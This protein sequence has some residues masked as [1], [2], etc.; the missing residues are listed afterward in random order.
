MSLTQVRPT[1][2]IILSFNAMLF[3]L[4]TALFGKGVLKVYNECLDYVVKCVRVMY[5]VKK[6]QAERAVTQWVLFNVELCAGW[7]NIAD[8]DDMQAYEQD[9]FGN[10]GWRCRRYCAQGRCGH[11]QGV[12]W[13]QDDWQY[14]ADQGRLDIWMLSTR[15]EEGK[16]LITLVL[17]LP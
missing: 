9:K 11:W 14:E 4:K 15:V 13:G 3:V 12:C 17:C 5:E 16:T 10:D 1:F 6:K 7:H 2:T 8:M